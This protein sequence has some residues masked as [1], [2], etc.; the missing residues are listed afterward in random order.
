ML[1]LL[2]IIFALNTF[3]PPA[4]GLIA[5]KMMDSA[6]M[7]SMNQ[8]MDNVPDAEMNCSMH[9]GNSCNSTQCVTNC[10]VNSPPLAFGSVKDFNIDSLGIYPQ[11][12]SQFLYRIFL[13][14]N[15]PPPLV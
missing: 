12:I 11:S 8:S 13:P 5:C 7:V 1:R 14:V 4:S 15:T 10:A 9:D 6:D 2:I 3:A